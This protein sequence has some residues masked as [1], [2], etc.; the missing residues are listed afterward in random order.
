[1][2]GGNLTRPMGNS[3]FENGLRDVDGDGDVD[4]LA[5]SAKILSEPNLVYGDVATQGRRLSELSPMPE[6]NFTIS[7]SELT[8]VELGNS[9]N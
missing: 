7:Q 9:V 5:V 2:P 6:T 3:H 4:L 1:M 8:I